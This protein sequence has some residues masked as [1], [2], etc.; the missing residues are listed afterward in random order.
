[1]IINVFRRT[2]VCDAVRMAA[3]SVGSAGWIATMDKFVG[4]SRRIHPSLAERLV[5][6]RP[7]ARPSGRFP[8]RYARLLGRVIGSRRIDL[9]TRQKSLNGSCLR[10]SGL[11]LNRGTRSSENI[12]R[13]EGLPAGPKGQEIKRRCATEPRGTGRQGAFDRRRLPSASG[14]PF[15]HLC[16]PAAAR[17][18]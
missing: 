10:G 6:Y 3:A 4:S 12:E 8:S 13:R 9:H 2:L 16:F 17:H 7:S 18:L 15:R 14:R 5:S 1:M 11:L